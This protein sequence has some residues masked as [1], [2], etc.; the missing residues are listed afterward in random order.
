MLPVGYLEKG[1][2]VKGK[3]Y[4][5]F[6]KRLLGNIKKNRPEM[7][8]NGVLSAATMLLPKNRWWHWPKSMTLDSDSSL[9]RLSR[10]A[11]FPPTCINAKT[12]KNMV[13]KCYGIFD[14]VIN[15]V[16]DHLN[17]FH[18][19]HALEELKSWE[20][21]SSYLAYVQTCQ[22]FYGQNFKLLSFHFL[23]EAHN[24]SDTPRITN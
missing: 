23:W 14:D 13:G 19:E 4:A 20:H 10:H 8:A 22:R 7:L 21:Q 18:F 1:H 5:D 17:R 12:W 3:Y 9:T 11:W 2:N 6:L 16:D 24:L 15:A